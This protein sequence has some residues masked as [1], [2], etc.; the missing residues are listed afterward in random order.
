MTN[1][2]NNVAPPKPGRV[3]QYASPRDTFMS[4]GSMDSGD[5]QCKKECL[6]WFSNVIIRSK[7]DPILHNNHPLHPFHTSHHIDCLFN[8]V[9]DGELTLSPRDI[10]GDDDEYVPIPEGVMFDTMGSAW[11]G[12]G[13]TTIDQ[14]SP[15][16]MFH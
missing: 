3:P 13:S 12:G 6:F 9:L 2:D 14:P 15:N 5:Q 11:S 10:D 7:F 16:F 4:A 1:N 8:Y